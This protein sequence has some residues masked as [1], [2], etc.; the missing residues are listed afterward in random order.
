MFNLCTV[1]IFFYCFTPSLSTFG[2][3]STKMTLIV[4]PP[5]P[6]PPSWSLSYQNNAGPERVNNIEEMRNAMKHMIVKDFF[7]TKVET[8][9]SAVL[10]GP[11]HFSQDFII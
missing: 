1:I 4:F 10:K 8:A 5:T 3:P 2:T 9:D 11:P 6:P 7:F